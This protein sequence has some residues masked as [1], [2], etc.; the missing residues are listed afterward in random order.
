MVGQKIY[1]GVLAFLRYLETRWGT[2][3]GYFFE[4]KEIDV[5]FRPKSHPRRLSNPQR[6]NFDI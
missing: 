2:F 4:R 5:Y 1:L 6:K 3:A